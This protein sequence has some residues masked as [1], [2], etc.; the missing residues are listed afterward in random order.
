MKAMLITE[1]KKMFDSRTL[2]WAI[3]IGMGISLINVLENYNLTRWFYDVQS[4]LNL[5]SYGTL[6][7]FHNWINGAQE[8]VGE[9]VYFTV[10]PVLAA[11]PY[12]WSLRSEIRDGYIE[13]ILTRGNKKKYLM[14]KYVSVFLSGGVVIIFSMVL[15]FMMNAWFLPT[16]PTLHIL[17][18][19]GDGLFLSRVLFA[20]PMLYVL[21]CLVTSFI[22]AGTL[23][24]L[25]LTIS[26]FLKNTVVIVLAPF[27]VFF[28]GSMISAALTKPST[29]IGIVENLVTDPM[30]LLHAM[31]LDYNPAWYVWMM[32][33]LLLSLVSVVYFYQGVRDEML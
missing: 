3:L 27:L 16:C 15:N 2:Q 6:S 29:E 14:A 7:I 23:A 31:T 33:L 17:V 8:T 25:G 18:G 12:S 28:S 26:L 32:L 10:F 22:W 11:I 19:G 24:C 20:R 9:L 5:P 21:L 4:N 1:L 30:Q 13:Q